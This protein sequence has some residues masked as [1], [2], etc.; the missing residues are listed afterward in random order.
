MALRVYLSANDLLTSSINNGGWI[1]SE[2]LV[3]VYV[4]PLRTSL[5]DNRMPPQKAVYGEVYAHDSST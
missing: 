4:V 5:R 2:K 1:P 3:Q